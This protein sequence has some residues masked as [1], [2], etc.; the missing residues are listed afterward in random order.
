ML[1]DEPFVVQYNPLH[2]HVFRDV[3]PGTHTVRVYA[4]DTMH[5]AV[6][7]SLAVVTFSVTYPND[8]NRPSVGEPLLT[9]NL[10]QGEYMGLDAGDIYLNFIVSGVD[11]KPNGYKVYYFV[12]GRRFVATNCRTYPLKKLEAGNHSVRVELVDPYGRLVNGP[13]NSAERIILVSPEKTPPRLK[14][15]DGAPAQP[16]IHS[17]HGPMTN[18]MPWVSADEQEAERDAAEAER[19]TR[20]DQPTPTTVA[21]RKNVGDFKVRRESAPSQR[22]ETVERR[23]GAAAESDVRKNPSSDKTPNAGDTGEDSRI[24]RFKKEPKT[25]PKSAAVKRETG[26]FRIRD[27]GT[28]GSA[29]KQSD[30]AG[31][32]TVKVTEMTTAGAVVKRVPATPP[33]PTPSPTPAPIV[34][35]APTA[36][37]ATPAPVAAKPDTPVPPSAND[38]TTT[39]VAPR[40]ER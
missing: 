17:L 19:T 7:G 13:F 27:E 14:R 32:S 11:L 20:E 23:K 36:P 25:T 2:P 38:K 5:Q 15:S 34:T 9:Y 40:S 18:G 12:D 21:P 35:P 31:I 30:K 28:T 6:P 29:A 16:V 24:E 33:P 22:I 37:M 39:G 4:A 8:E 3:R 1:D 10:P 26:D